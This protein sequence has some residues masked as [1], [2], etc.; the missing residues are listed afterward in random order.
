[1]SERDISHLIG[2]IRLN[3][4]CA[5]VCSATGDIMLRSNKG[6]TGDSSKRS[7]PLASRSVVF[8]LRHALRMPSGIGIARLALRHALLAPAPAM[9]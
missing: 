9:Q 1:M 4:D 5:A 7:L 3:L 8:V 6:A 2:C